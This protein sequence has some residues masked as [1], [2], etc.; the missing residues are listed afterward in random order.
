MLSIL[1][2]HVSR[3]HAPWVVERS[4]EPLLVQ[5]RSGLSDTS[6]VFGAIDRYLLHEMT[7]VRAPGAAIVIVKGDRIVHARGFG[8]ADPSGGPI[9]PITPFILGSMTKSFTALAVMQLAESGRLTLDDPVQ[10]YLPWFHVRDRSASARITIRHLLNQTSGLPKSAGLQ[11]IRGANATTQR[12]EMRL[13]E[14][15]RLHYEPGEGFEYSNANYWLLGLIVER[16]AGEPF[17]AYVRRRI[18]AP[19]QMQRSFTSESEAR[20]HGLAQGYRVW[21]GFPRA[22]AMPYYA[23]ELSV[24]Y[25]I[26]DAEDVGRY[27]IAHLNGGR[28][29][30][31]SVVSAAGL[32][33][34]HTP[35]RGFPYAMG[36]LTDFVAGVP[37][38]WHTGAVA[39]Y[40]GDML[41]MPSA[42]WG[43]AVLSNV[44]NFLLE[45]QFSGAIKG[46]AALLLGYQPASPSWL[47]YRTLYWLITALAIVW[48][49]WRGYQVVSLRRWIKRADVSTVDR[50]EL[51]RHP[52][53]TLIDPG[54]S[55]GLLFGVPAFL[56]APLSTMMWFAPDMTSWLVVN[57]IV[58]VLVFG[59]R[60]ALLAPSLRRESQS[61]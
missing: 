58:S 37:V 50:N 2:R 47:R 22:Q 57:T 21:F 13:F 30:D 16:A 3:L 41:L 5:L 6:Q 44:N 20:A 4:R 8:R 24:G 19:L 52:A 53:L 51:I 25:L 59:L 32:A 49:V 36:W 27:L 9:T 28:V 17:D 26:S 38:L 12:D 29:D 55:I 31:T 18:F 43:I 60:L 14:R 34:L 54:L 48:L 46:A 56:E 7:A 35:P 23:R 39:N 11:L 42:G 33:Q 61:L 45:T 1:L 15:V 40:H 10:R